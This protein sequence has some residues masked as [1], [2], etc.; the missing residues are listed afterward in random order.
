MLLQLAWR[1]SERALERCERRAVSNDYFHGSLLP[2]QAVSSAAVDGRFSFLQLRPEDG[3]GAFA[4]L[5]ACLPAGE[6]S[7]FA[8]P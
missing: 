5:C 8:H 7:R 1:R 4:P 2:T 3:G 6:H